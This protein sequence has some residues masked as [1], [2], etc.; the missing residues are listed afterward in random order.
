MIKVKKRKI[1]LLPGDGIG[2]EVISEVKKIIES[3]TPNNQPK[4]LELQLVG[5]TIYV[6]MDDILYCKA[7]SNYT[8]VHLINEQKE[9]LS[10]KLKDLEA[11]TNASFFRVHN[12][13]LV[14]INYIKEFVKNEGLYL[15]LVNGNTIPVSRSK[16]NELQQLLNN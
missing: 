8:E 9:M 11:Q 10:K 1:L 5:K 2:P 16:K 6:N 7:D 14:N 15:V 3:F 13:Y 4:R 12:S